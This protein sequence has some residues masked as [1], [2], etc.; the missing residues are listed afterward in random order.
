MLK[1]YARNSNIDIE[2]IL[3]PCTKKYKNT[4]IIKI[5]IVST[6]YIPVVQ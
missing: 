2:S 4:K 1:K 6:I 3:N 5:Q